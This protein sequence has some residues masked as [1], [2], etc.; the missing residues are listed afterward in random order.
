MFTPNTLIKCEKEMQFDRIPEIYFNDASNYLCESNSHVRYNNDA[1]TGSYCKSF[2]FIENVN[3]KSGQCEYFLKNSMSV[4]AQ[5]S[6]YE[7]FKFGK[8]SG[9]SLGK[10][11]SN[12]TVNN[13]DMLSIGTLDDTMHYPM[14]ESINY[15]FDIPMSLAPK[16]KSTELVNVVDGIASGK[17]IV[18]ISR[19]EVIAGDVKA[20]VIGSL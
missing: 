12:L 20:K 4:C 16:E 18:H 7:K 13:H 10:L 2:S 19:F 14:D 8:A 5:S 17:F 15:E 1:T 6:N 9:T 3:N 11:N